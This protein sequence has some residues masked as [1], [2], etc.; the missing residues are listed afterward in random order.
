MPPANEWKIVLADDEADIRDVLTLTLE[1]AGYRT[2]SA[3]DGRAAMELCRSVRPQIVITDIR[4]PKMTGLEL[5]ESLKQF[6]PDTE[7]IVATAFGEMDLA[8]R[9]LQLDASDFINKPI[10]DEALHLALHRARNR[11][12]ARRELRDYAALLEK[13]KA[14]TVREL[15]RVVAFRN[16]LIEHSMDGIVAC[17]DSGRV[18]VYNRSME[19]LL[20]FSKER[21][22]GK[23]GLEEIFQ[24]E[25]MERFKEE[26]G[27]SGF[28]GTNRLFLFETLLRGN[29]GQEIPVQVS[30]SRLFNEGEPVGVV[31]FF[32][33]LR[34]LRR[35]ESQMADQA[36]ILHQDKMISLGRLSASVV[37]EINNPLSGI[38]N[39]LRLML[40][41]MERGEL[42][43]AHQANFHRY[44]TLVE[45]ETGRCSQIVSNLLTF[46]RKSPAAFDAVNIK[47]LINRCVL[48]SRHKMELSG[49]DL[50]TDID[51]AL[52]VIRGDFN[53]LQQCLINLVFNAVDA[54]P[55]GGALKITAAPS[56]GRDTRITLT[57]ADTG[58][59]IA[60]KDLPHIFEPFYSTKSEGY[61][62]G[63]GLSTVYGIVE[64][65][66][67]S[68]DVSSRL[69]KGT[70]FT[71]DLPSHQ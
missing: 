38:L 13:E 25:E 66:G 11:Y 14:E 27:G 6:R 19:N 3:Q 23:V 43:P 10:N 2:W 69:G 31:C 68:I 17:D 50:T 62:V 52:P 63:L 53:Q 54:M 16:N 71:M 51:P 37:H 4:M 26:L 59:G 30:A 58:R 22:I 1:D 12:L 45:S 24:S 48:L 20:G 70:T 8:I 49:I 57:I 41:I 15:A 65:H 18:L 42:T 7:V 35:L 56:A 36:R 34:E 60:E 40:R 55:D 28:G 64:R 32:R 5:L 44:L 61:G 29:S 39:Y 67:G 33:D 46:S 21:I 9:A 47:D